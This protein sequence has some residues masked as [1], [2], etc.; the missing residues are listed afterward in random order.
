[1]EHRGETNS[2]NAIF[3]NFGVE[4]E[5]DEGRRGR[6]GIGVDWTKLSSVGCFLIISDPLI[7][8]VRRRVV[9]ICKKSG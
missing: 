2:K 4:M 6:F 7:D 3:L 5:V 8:I 1:M 9:I